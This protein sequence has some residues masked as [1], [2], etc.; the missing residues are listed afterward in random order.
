[1]VKGEAMID[2]PPEYGITCNCGMR[3]SGTNENGVISLMKRHLESGKYHTAYLLHNGFEPGDTE[4]EKIIINA[5]SMKK[6][7]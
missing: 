4:L 2:S 5:T 3:I 6:G 7:L 1:M